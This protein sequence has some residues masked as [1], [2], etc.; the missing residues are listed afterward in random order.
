MIPL[1]LVETIFH[2]SWALFLPV[3]LIPVVVMALTNNSDT[4][5]SSAVVW[6]SNPVASERPA[7]GSNNPYLSPAQNQAQVVNDLLSTRAFRTDVAVDAGIIPAGASESITRRGAAQVRAFASASG[8]NLVTVSAISPSADVAQKVVTSVIDSYLARATT[9]IES[10]SKV[11]A[12]YYTQQLTLAQQSLAA[13]GAEIASYL[14]SNPRAA[15]PTDPASQEPAFLTLVDRRNSQ[16]TL[17]ASLQATLQAIELRAASAPQTQAAMFTLQ[18]PATRP[19][20]PLPVSMTSKYGKP[21]AGAMLGLFIGVAYLYVAYRTDHTIRSAEDLQAAGVPLLGSVPQLK[22]APAWARH[23]P[24]AWLISWRNR[25]FA[26]KTA[27][28]IT[29]PQPNTRNTELA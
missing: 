22:A 14:G 21:A 17:V 23:T 13:T 27:A 12:E 7:L 11:S 29:T 25:D 15:D 18:D 28:S 6:T 10:D 16:A 1:K 9:A 2:K 20:A 24:L 5:Q 8:V 26:R 19:E 3:L 4:Y